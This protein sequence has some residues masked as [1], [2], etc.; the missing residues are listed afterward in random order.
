MRK[1]EEPVMNVL[2]LE[3]EDVITLSEGD[4]QKFDPEIKGE[5]GV[6]PWA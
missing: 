6:N 3:A 5:N 4:T 2:V 1:Y